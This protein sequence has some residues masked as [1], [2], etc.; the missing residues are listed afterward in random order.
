[1]D[2]GLQQVLDVAAAAAAAA[3]ALLLL[4]LL[5]WLA[6]SHVTAQECGE[7]CQV[8]P[9]LCVSLAPLPPHIGLSFEELA[10]QLAVLC[11]H[12]GGC[13]AWWVNGSGGVGRPACFEY[14]CVINEILLKLKHW[15]C[16]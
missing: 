13:P 15:V 10:G 6:R 1:V 5:V 14:F 4:L 2:G 16:D 11:R 9:E 7:A 12:G 8:L 3:A